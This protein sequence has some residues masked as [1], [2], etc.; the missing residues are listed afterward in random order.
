M[1][2][3]FLTITLLF[4]QNLL[5]QEYKFDR[6]IEYH[7]DNSVLIFMLNSKDSSYYFT[8]KNFNV[9][10]S[11]RIIDNKNMVN[12]EYSIINNKK[13]NSI[14][15]NYLG[16]ELAQKAKFPCYDKNNLYE[17]KTLANDSASINFKII[18]YKNVKKNKVSE[19]S[20][21][22]SIVYDVPVF[23]FILKNIFYHFVYCQKLNFKEEFLLPKKVKINYY[24]GNNVMTELVQNKTINTTLTLTKEIIKYNN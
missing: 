13:F 1:K 12:H 17:I 20:E 2:N 18:K 16:S 22:N 15:F 7:D 9:N 5:C 19:T 10:L 21:I 11:G 23:S 8:S 14:N 24:N 3:L 6:Y 4:I